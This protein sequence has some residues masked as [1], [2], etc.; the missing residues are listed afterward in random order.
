MSR[1]RRWA[2]MGRGKFRT[3]AAEMAAEFAA[4]ERLELPTGVPSRAELALLF[5]TARPHFRDYL[6]SRLLYFSGMR[7]KE[8]LSFVVGDVVWDLRSIF[9]R[10]G[11]GDKDR[12]VLVD[13]GTLELLREWI[14]SAPP[15]RVV[16]PL[17][18]YWSDNNFKK[19][20]ED[21]GLYQKFQDRGLRL[22][23][24]SMRH[25]FATH[26][27][28]EGLDFWMVVALLGHAF[29]ETTAVY[30]RTASRQVAGAYGACN[31]FAVGR[32]EF[33]G[34]SQEPSQPTWPEAEELQREFREQPQAVRADG[35]PAV[36]SP[37]E[38]A[39]FLE[40]ARGEYY[41]ALRLLYAT[42]MWS[43]ELL[44]LDWEDVVWEEGQICAGGR[45]VWVDGTTL[46]LLRASQ[47]RGPMFG[48]EPSELAAA[49]DDY[50][51]RIGLRQR[52]EG[53][54]RA[55]GVDAIRYAFA[56]HCCIRGIDRIS[57]MRLLGHRFVATG[58][59]YFRSAPGRFL[60]AFDASLGG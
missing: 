11:K 38:M 28:E 12:Y 16:F 30:L 58:E 2:V 15:G 51:G 42:G 57:L 33:R 4:E 53:M 36:P 49:V 47:G 8:L 13:A 1:A 9:V 18:I 6:M 56:T 21:C 5:E 7:R 29:M 3:G 54:G 44:A 34:N 59:S 46:D 60:T 41:L 39:A 48:L 35:L 26:H 23:V 14:G 43:S 27:Y 10:G 20:C 40:W 24:H 50:G 37:G 22:S 31:P 19:L 55:F 52:F 45:R 17:S 32:S 25:A